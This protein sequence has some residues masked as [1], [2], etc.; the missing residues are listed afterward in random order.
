MT[1]FAFAGKCGFFGVSGFRKVLIP[2]AATAC[3][4]RK[5]SSPSRAASASETK[6]PPAC[7][8]NS[9]RVRPQNS[10][11]RFGRVESFIVCSRGAGAASVQIDEFVEV[12]RH[13]AEVA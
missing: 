12:Q 6:P 1:L 13:E 5:P 10:E 4:A 2:S 9:R 3:V 11:V 7:Q 8:R